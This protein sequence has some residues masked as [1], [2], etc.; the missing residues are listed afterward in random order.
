VLMACEGTHILTAVVVPMSILD[1]RRVDSSLFYASTGGW[2]ENEKFAKNKGT[3][4]WH[5]V[6][7]TPVEGS[8]DRTWNEQQKLLGQD[9]ETPSARA[10]IL[11]IIG[12]YRATGE[13]L[14]PNVY[15]RCSCVGSD[16]DHV[17]VGA[18]GSDGVDVSS[19]WD[20]RRFNI[21]LSSARKF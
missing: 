3:I 8:T 6:R 12:Y 17:Y 7:K 9:D 10:M 16:G 19:W 13:R 14:F 5:L 15:V 21:G 4:G 18:F 20:R 1:V 11:T 2:H